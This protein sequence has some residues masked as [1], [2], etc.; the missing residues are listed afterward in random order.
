MANNS[1]F[2]P[3]EG[4]APYLRYDAERGT[5]IISP[6]AVTTI[7]GDENS[8]LEIGQNWIAFAAGLIKTPMDKVSDKLLPGVT[9]F[10]VTGGKATCSVKI[11]SRG[12][13]TMAYVLYDGVK[14]VNAGDVVEVPC[15]SEIIVY[16][17]AGR[18]NTVSVDGKTVENG[19]AV[20]YKYVVG[21]DIEVDFNMSPGSG[22][23]VEIVSK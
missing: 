2:Y 15:G 10:G 20:E 22:A 1:N 13:D 4:Y 3:V 11:A 6:A 21:A 14:Y 17:N 19:G 9:V 23:K 5:F 18:T 8:G 12:F 7:G 16:A